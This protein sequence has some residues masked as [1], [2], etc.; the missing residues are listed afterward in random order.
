M[1]LK[2]SLQQT[3]AITTAFNFRVI[4]CQIPYK[5][6]NEICPSTFQGRWFSKLFLS[7][8]VSDSIAYVSVSLP[9]AIAYWTDLNK[10]W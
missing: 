7:V 9:Y 10:A 8:C 6:L 2:N 1:N 3:F 4:V 5:I